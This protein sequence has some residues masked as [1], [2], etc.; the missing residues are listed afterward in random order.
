MTETDCFHCETS[1]LKQHKSHGE[2][3]RIRLALILYPVDPFLN[4][5]LSSTC[6]KSRVQCFINAGVMNKWFLLNPEKNFK[7]IHF[8]VFEKSALQFQINDVTEPK[9]RLL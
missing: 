5:C 4:Y 7:L 9:A 6:F 8:V 2:T 3:S 1:F